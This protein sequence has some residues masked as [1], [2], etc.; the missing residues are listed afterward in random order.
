MV[1]PLPP[2]TI[3]QLM[4]LRER[5]SKLR[6]GHFI[7][8]SGSGE[9]TRLLLEAGWAG[10]A[11]D[12]ESKT[13]DDLGRRFAKEVAVGHLAIVNDDYLSTPIG[14][15]ADLVISSRVIESHG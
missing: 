8:G 13:T 5:L 1:A 12:L 3:L 15:D 4:Y 2:G 6:P 9:I 11:Y 10:S 14:S 7:K